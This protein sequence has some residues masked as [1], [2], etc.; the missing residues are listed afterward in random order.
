MVIALNTLTQ[1]WPSRCELHA[2]LDLHVFRGGQRVPRAVVGSTSVAV[3]LYS[4]AVQPSAGRYPQ[5]SATRTARL[6]VSSWR[7]GL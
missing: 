2:I 5:P 3:L 7:T 1:L 6:L 4:G